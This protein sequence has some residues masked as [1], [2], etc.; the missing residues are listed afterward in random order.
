MKDSD[1]KKPL[2]FPTIEFSGRYSPQIPSQSIADPSYTSSPKTPDPHQDS[3]S[4]VELLGVTPKDPL[5]R[6]HNTKVDQQ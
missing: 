4:N 3:S 5:Y 2:N 6:I 1:S